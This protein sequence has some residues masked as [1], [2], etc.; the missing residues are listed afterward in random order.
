MWWMQFATKK[1]PAPEV[2]V[3][4]N[5]V[6]QMESATR[7]E[8]TFKSGDTITYREGEWDDYGYDGKA[9]SVKLKGAW[10]GIYNFDHVFSV[11]LKP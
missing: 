2:K 7:L 11:E 4:R 10:V 8:I 1:N 6:N 3:G 5:E 9:I